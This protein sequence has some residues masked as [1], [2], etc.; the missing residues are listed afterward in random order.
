MWVLPNTHPSEMARHHGLHFVFY[1]GTMAYTLCFTTAPWLTLCV[2]LRHHGLHVVYYYGTM[3]YISCFTNI[4][5]P[6]GLK[7]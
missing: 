1:Y 5:R 4:A 6:K 3:A 2:L 7:W